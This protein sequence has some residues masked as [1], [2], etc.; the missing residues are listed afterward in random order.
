LARL[1][2][3]TPAFKRLTGLLRSRGLN[4]WSDTGP[5]VY[6]LDEGG[7]PGTV[8]GALYGPAVSAVG[9]TADWPLPV[10]GAARRLLSDPAASFRKAGSVVVY[11]IVR[12]GR[13]AHCVEVNFPAGGQREARAHARVPVA[14]AA[15]V[16][17]GAW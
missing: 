1:R 2:I 11:T 7:A 10:R 13:A 4:P 14:C 12:V 9:V 15:S 16:L 17:D 6:V 5:T 3:S 8:R